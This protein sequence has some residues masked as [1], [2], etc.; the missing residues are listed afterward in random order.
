MPQGIKNRR[1]FAAETKG[2][3]EIYCNVNIAIFPEPYWSCSL[4][5]P[6][7]GLLPCCLF[8]RSFIQ[9]EFIIASKPRLSIP[10]NRPFTLKILR[11][12]DSPGTRTPNLGIKSALLCQLS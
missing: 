6:D 9:A 8:F 2:H 10:Q 4:C 3:M 7:V 12:N 5:P 1:A 11:E